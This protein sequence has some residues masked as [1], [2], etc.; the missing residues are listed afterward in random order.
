MSRED[1]PQRDIPPPLM[2]L[3]SVVS[4][5]F[6]MLEASL[7][8]DFD[9]DIFFEEVEFEGEPPRLC[10]TVSDLKKRDNFICLSK[11]AKKFSNTAFR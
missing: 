11:G 8:H 4:Y 6:D 3:F 9:V 2:A 7:Q 1:V 5:G 10:L